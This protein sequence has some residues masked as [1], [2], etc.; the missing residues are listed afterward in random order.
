MPRSSLGQFVRGQRLQVLAEGSHA[1]LAEAAAVLQAGERQVRLVQL[2][3]VHP[4][5]DLDAD[6]GLEI[7]APDRVVAVHQVAVVLAVGA[8]HP[9]GVQGVAVDVA[10]GA[11]LEQVGDWLAVRLL[12]SPPGK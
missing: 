8:L 12:T 2:D 5:V 6:D 9:A 10:R 3:A 7:L 1:V 11:L 4:G